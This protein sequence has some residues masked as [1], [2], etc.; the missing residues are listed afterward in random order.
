MTMSEDG[1][2]RTNEL[3]KALMD[4]TQGDQSI[5]SAVQA[6]KDVLHSAPPQ[7]AANATRPASEWEFTKEI[8]W[9]ESTGRRPMILRAHSQADLDALERQVLYGR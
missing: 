7:P 9:A 2:L 5:E 3:D 4:A 1:I 6:M 8:R